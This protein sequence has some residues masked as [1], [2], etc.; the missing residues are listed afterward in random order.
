MSF[1]YFSPFLFLPYPFSRSTSP[2]LS[3]SRPVKTRNATL[4]SSL[5][6]VALLPW[7]G[8]SACSASTAARG[9]GQERPPGCGGTSHARSSAANI[10]CPREVVDTAVVR[11]HLRPALARFCACATHQL[12]SFAQRAAFCYGSAPTFCS[13]AA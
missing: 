5:H 6:L 2:C 4:L 7:H 13:T 11:S 10:F 9:R 1:S 12:L 3:P 8:C